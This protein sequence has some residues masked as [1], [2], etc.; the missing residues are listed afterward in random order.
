MSINYNGCKVDTSKGLII[1]AAGRE[2][3][4]ELRKERRWNIGRRK[5][6]LEL[7]GEI[8]VIFEGR[9]YRHFK[10]WSSAFL[11]LSQYN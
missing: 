2:Y 9:S 8:T 7:T 10:D 1:T 3:G 5:H 11:Y 4:Y 6:I